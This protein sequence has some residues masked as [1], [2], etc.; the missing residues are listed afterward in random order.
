MDS[1]AP[2]S[3]ST[4]IVHVAAAEV[5]EMAGDADYVGV[6]DVVEVVWRLDPERDAIGGQLAAR[7]ENWGP[8]RPRKPRWLV[9]SPPP[10]S[11]M[12]RARQMTPCKSCSR[13]SPIAGQSLQPVNGQQRFQVRVRWTLDRC[14]RESTDPRYHW[15][16][17]CPVSIRPTPSRAMHSDECGRQSWAI[18][19]Q[20]KP[21]SRFRALGPRRHWC[22]PSGDRPTSP[23]CGPG[24][25]PEVQVIH[26]HKGHAVGGQWR[27]CGL[28]GWLSRGRRRRRGGGSL[29][30]ADAWVVGGEG[31]HCRCGSQR[32]LVQEG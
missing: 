31:W 17:A 26:G 5:I 25:S 32:E 18:R 3:R 29:A 27:R 20:P 6:P 16:P 21:S 13:C 10:R 28:R 15:T 8:T 19:Y 23:S 22:P 14:G 9:E 4:L 7:C 24:F 11:R 1:S 30:D 2:K 12:H